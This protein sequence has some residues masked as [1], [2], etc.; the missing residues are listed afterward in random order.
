MIT[1]SC[2]QCQTSMEV[3]DTLAGRSGLC[4]NCHQSIQIPIPH[5]TTKDADAE[6]IISVEADAGVSSPSYSQQQLSS[7]SEGRKCTH[8]GDMVPMEVAFCRGCG[9]YVPG[10]I[11]PKTAAPDTAIAKVRVTMPKIDSTVSASNDMPS[12][13]MSFLPIL[14][15]LFGLAGIVS[16]YLA[17]A[18]MF[19]AI[20]CIIKLPA[21]AAMAKRWSYISVVVSLLVMLVVGSLFAV[22]QMENRK[23]AGEWVSVN[24]AEEV[25]SI[26]TD[27]ANKFMVYINDSAPLVGTINKNG[28]LEIHNRYLEQRAT[29]KKG[30]LLWKA[31]NA[32]DRYRKK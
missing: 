10:N 1:F 26:K 25:V 20:Y 16:I 23:Y 13:A 17:L 2:P 24:D 7:D 19:L 21:S 29:I 11:T 18:G 9:S 22:K 3:P 5:V 15:L 28:S 32:T 6:V 4:P 12:A 14:A 30:E 31:G 8:C 27:G